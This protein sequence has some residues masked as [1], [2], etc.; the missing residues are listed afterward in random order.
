[1]GFWDVVTGRTRPKQAEPRLAVPGAERRDH[2]ADRGRAAADRG[3]R[4]LLPRGRRRG[5]PA[6]PGRGRRR[7]STD[8]PTAPDVTI[9]RDEFG[10]TWLLAHRDPDDTAGLCTDLHAVNTSL[11]AQGFGPGLLCSLVPF[12]DAVRPPGRPRLPLQ[13][14]HVLPVRA[15]RPGS[16]RQ[17]ARD[18][19]PRPPGRRAADGAGPGSLAGAVGSAR[20]VSPSPA[21]ADPG[22]SPP[23]VADCA[24]RL[25]G[26]GAPTDE[27]H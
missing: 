13:A 14:G 12:A 21:E 9:S 4:R 7:C 6:D 23:S 11:E 8:D 16:P 10:F 22:W 1:M 15:H 3:R 18:R 27:H 17:P 24:R 25:H 2:P 20:P 26:R 5:V 19:G